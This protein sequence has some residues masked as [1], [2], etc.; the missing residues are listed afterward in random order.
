MAI[1]QCAEMLPVELADS[2]E[3]C[4]TGADRPIALRHGSFGVSVGKH[5]TVL[6]HQIFSGR[7]AMAYPSLRKRYQPLRRV[8]P[9]L[10][11]LYISMRPGKSKA[12]LSLLLRRP[13][14]IVL[15]TYKWL[16]G[17]VYLAPRTS[18][19]W[20]SPGRAVAVTEL[21]YQEVN[22]TVIALGVCLRYRGLPYGIWKS[23]EAGHGEPGHGVLPGYRYVRSEVPYR[24]GLVDRRL[25][26][27]A[28]TQRAPAPA[29]LP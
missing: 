10:Q 25:P 2:E 19:E 18:V 22:R 13:A 9:E 7:R 3:V 20:Y 28:N 21:P 8:P 16:P 14:G 4:R 26:V 12:L 23:S 15:G 29:V 17:R 5:S 6:W 11:A 27:A 24:I 1:W